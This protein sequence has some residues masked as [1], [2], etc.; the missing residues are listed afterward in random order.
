MLG[1]ENTIQN[2]DL[3]FRMAGGNTFNQQPMAS[4]AGMYSDRVG[5]IGGGYSHGSMLNSAP[6]APAQANAIHKR[7]FPMH[8][9]QFDSMSNPGF[10]AYKQQQDMY[11]G[12]IND[13]NFNHGQ[14]NMLQNPAMW[15]MGIGNN[16]YHP[17]QMQTNYD[18]FNNSTVAMNGGESQIYLTK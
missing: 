14:Q 11:G 17:Q 13:G 6:G 2:A 3:Y 1:N 16:M 18:Q 15:E 8:H 10:S 7:N 12:E 9:P 5:V 4:L